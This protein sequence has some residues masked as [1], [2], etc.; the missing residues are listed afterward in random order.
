MST[1]TAS[2]Q[3]QYRQLVHD[4][5]T[6]DATIA[7]WREWH[8]KMTVQ[9]QAMTDAL[10]EVAHV[11]PGLRILDLGSGTGQPALD[12]A[13]ATGPTGHVTATDL[14]PAMLTLA[15]EHA[16]AAGLANI[17]FRQADAEALPFPDETFDAVTS[18]LGAMYFVDIQRALGEIRRV[19][20]PGGHVAL[21]V[22]GPGDQGTYIGGMLGPFFQR[23]TLP[24]PPPDAPSPFR[25]AAPGALGGALRRAGFQQETERTL[26]VPAPW[27]GT[28]EEYWQQFYEVAVPM[29]PVFD[30]LP[31]EEFVQAK[32]EA[33]DILRTHYDGSTVHASVAIVVA[34]GTK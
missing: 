32:A 20:K 1:A 29:R 12:L 7:A 8:P 15:E 31:P 28:P 10:L 3:A 23:A 26:V 18:R 33:A 5:W 4:E 2:Q 19:L 16:R 17:A 9:L 14:S 25:F 24:A 21:A 13:R 22:W 6:D 30:S 27:P 11:R 34:S